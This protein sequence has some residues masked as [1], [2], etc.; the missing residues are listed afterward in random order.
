LPFK[1]IEVCIGKDFYP[2]ATAVV[3]T[4]R[5]WYVDLYESNFATRDILWGTKDSVEAAGETFDIL[6]NKGQGA[7]FA[8]LSNHQVTGAGGKGGTRYSIYLYDDKERLVGSSVSSDG[9]YIFVLQGEAPPVK[10]R[11]DWRNPWAATQDAAQ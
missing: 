4:V 9:E 2:G 1:D 11:V 3:F 6:F 5:S 7:V 8:S 10:Y